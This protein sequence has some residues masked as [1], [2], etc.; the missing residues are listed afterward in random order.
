MEPRL[1]DWLEYPSY[2][3]EL[4]ERLDATE[5]N[6]KPIPEMAMHVSRFVDGPDMDEVYP[7]IFLGD[8]DA[9]MNE[10]YLVSNGI[11][12]VLN[13][14][15]NYRGGPA[16]VKTGPD[17]YKDPSITFHGL[18]LIDLPFANITPHFE[19]GAVFIEKALKTGGRILV[20]CRQGR[21]R[22]TSVLIAFLMSRRNFT[23]SNALVMLKAAREINPNS[24]FLKELADLDLKLF[25]EKF[26]KWKEISSSDSSDSSSDVEM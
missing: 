10:K 14:A 15:Y 24:G 1:P 11:T 13:C 25:R 7:N 8:C 6:W 23:A 3:Y 19:P 20:H 2:A 16:C 18:E 17:Y 9:A 5:V 21:S 26:Q 22:S 4:K 12:H